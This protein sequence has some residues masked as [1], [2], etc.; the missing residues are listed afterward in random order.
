M[1]V[2]NKTTLRLPAGSRKYTLADSVAEQLREE[3]VGGQLA[4][5]SRVAEIPTAE[6]LGVSRVPV[7]EAT[8]VL[9]RDG[10]LVFEARGRCRVRTLT[11]RDFNE[12][13]SVRLLLE[14]EAFKLAARNHTSDDLVRMEANIKRMARARSLARMSLLDIEFH[15]L[16]LQAGRQSRLMHLWRVMR[17]QIQLFTAA[18]QREYNQATSTGP[19]TTVASHLEAVRIIKSRDEEAAEKCARR[20]LKSWEDWMQCTGRIAER[21]EMHA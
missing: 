13:Y 17:G 1:I 6:R 7:R 8:L 5:G 9:E 2:Y 4:P 20:H 11:A 10:L 15:D 12:I 16:I 21:Q 18:L 19:E 3:I 14:V